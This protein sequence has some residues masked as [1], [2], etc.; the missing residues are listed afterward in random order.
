MVAL[1]R[2]QGKGAAV[3]AGMLRARGEL[4]LFSDADLSTPIEE[5]PRLRERLRG[6]LHGGDRVAGG[7]RDRPSTSTSRDAGR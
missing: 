3:R 6:E 2:N 7:A 5:L 4:R 1:P